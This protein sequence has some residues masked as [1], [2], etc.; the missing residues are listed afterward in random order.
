MLN[1]LDKYYNLTNKLCNILYTDTP[2]GIR[3]SSCYLPL[4]TVGI[5][6]SDYNVVLYSEGISK[7]KL[8][9]HKIKT[10]TQD[11]DYTDFLKIILK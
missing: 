4:E 6:C 2:D 1:K 3:Y 10:N 7:I 8:V 9:E 5:E 11:F